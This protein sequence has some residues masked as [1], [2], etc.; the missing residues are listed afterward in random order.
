MALAHNITVLYAAS[1][2]LILG[3]MCESTV[4][5]KVLKQTYFRFLKF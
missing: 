3:I 5:R 4:F 2:G 1:N